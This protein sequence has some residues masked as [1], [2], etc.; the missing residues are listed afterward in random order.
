MMHKA[1]QLLLF[2]KFLESRL[3]VWNNTVVAVNFYRIEMSV[4]F[5]LQ[6]KK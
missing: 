2:S 1:A 5:S 6:K 4:F 3:L